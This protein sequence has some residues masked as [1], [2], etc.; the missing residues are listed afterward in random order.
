MRP[1]I[2]SS[3]IEHTLIEPAA[4]PASEVEGVQEFLT[5]APEQR[6]AILAITP[7]STDQP[8]FAHYLEASG[9][10]V[11]TANTAS[12][13]LDQAE[14]IPLDV[15]VL[16]LDGYYVTSRDGLMISG[17]RLLYLLRRLVGERPIAVMVV[18]EL[19]YAEVEGA[20]CAHADA[21]VNKPVTPGQLLARLRA[22]LE[23]VRSRCRQRLDLPHSWQPAGGSGSG[24][25]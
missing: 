25:G 21:L 2:V 22:A 11:Y 23:R 4:A 3:V 16:D 24:Q 20:V 12:E 1:S 8:A 9:Y 18:T 17:F 14:Q 13:A 15:I 10:E 6:P 19:D 5:V 7:P